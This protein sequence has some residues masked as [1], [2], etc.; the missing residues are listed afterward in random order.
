MK[1]IVVLIVVSGALLSTV[2][3]HLIMYHGFKLFPFPIF[4]AL[5]FVDGEMAYNLIYIDMALEVIAVLAIVVMILIKRLK[6]S[7]SSKGR[8]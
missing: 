4:Q 8:K 1:K 7:N 2:W 3:W 6:V 5:F